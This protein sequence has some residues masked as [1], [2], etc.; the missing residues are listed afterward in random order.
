MTFYYGLITVMP[1]IKHPLWAM[2]VGD[3]TMIKY[4]GACTLVAALV[5]LGARPT[6]LR[7]FDTPQALGF[8]CFAAWGIIAFLT[9]GPPYPFEMSALMSCI[10]FLL[11]F[12]VTHVL[13]DSF[14]RLKMSLLVAVGSVAFA[15]L[16]I[17]REWQN[18]S[19]LYGAGYRPGWVTGDP[20]YYSVSALLCLPLAFYLLR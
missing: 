14:G 6:P 7:M 15:S 16:Y 1:L 10:S 17:L 8:V 20:N 18:M 13:V 19:G 3:L 2:V 4:L 5:Y 11:L 9:M 12:F